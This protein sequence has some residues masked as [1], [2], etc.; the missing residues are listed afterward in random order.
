MSRVALAVG[1]LACM[2]SVWLVVVSLRPPS[3]APRPPASGAAA[4]SAAAPAPELAI[5]P[6]VVQRAPAEPLT[7]EPKQTARPVL[8]GRPRGGAATQ[9]RKPVVDAGSPPSPASTKPAPP[10]LLGGDMWDSG[11]H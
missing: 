3:V 10:T 9:E 2:L 1:A 5:V 6:A 11:A 8:K 7:P 4:T